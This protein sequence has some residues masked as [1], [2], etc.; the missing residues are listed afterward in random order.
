ME[1]QGGRKAGVAAWA[2]PP[3]T[4]PSA[5]LQHGR[6]CPPACHTEQGCAAVGGTSLHPMGHQGQESSGAKKLPPYTHFSHT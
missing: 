3:A 1:G 2:L 6:Q 4:F 5:F